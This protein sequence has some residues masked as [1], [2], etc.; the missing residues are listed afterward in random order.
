MTTPLKGW[1]RAA[2]VCM[3]SLSVA[4]RKLNNN[5]LIRVNTGMLFLFL[6]PDFMLKMGCNP[7]VHFCGVT[8]KAFLIVLSRS[9]NAVKTR[10]HFTT[11][12]SSLIT[13]VVLLLFFIII[14][15]VKSNIGFHYFE[16]QTI[17]IY[18]HCCPHK[19]SFITKQPNGVVKCDVTHSN[20]ATSGSN[21]LKAP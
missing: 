17:E 8:L 13:I 12:R 15:D 11:N 4:S 16:C 10:E 3:L 5:L 9:S 1:D 14:W 19:T 7:A 6:F 20:Q 18:I 21:L 2:N